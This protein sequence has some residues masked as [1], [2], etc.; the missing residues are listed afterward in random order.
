MLTVLASPAS[1]EENASPL[2]GKGL[3]G[4]LTGL[5]RGCGL[6]AERQGGNRLHSVNRVAWVRDRASVFRG[7][8]KDR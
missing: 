7:D 4:G 1:K 8:T 3:R 6:W 2:V 5:I